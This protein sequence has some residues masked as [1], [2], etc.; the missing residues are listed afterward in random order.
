MVTITDAQREQ[1]KKLNEQFSKWEI[2]QDQMK[3][4]FESIVPL[5]Q[6]KTYVQEKKDEPKKQL[7]EL[8]VDITWKKMTDQQLA[9]VARVEWKKARDQDRRF[10]NSMGHWSG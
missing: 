10:N 1:I 5:E 2:T 3:S 6:A 4:S 7:E 9:N 8:G